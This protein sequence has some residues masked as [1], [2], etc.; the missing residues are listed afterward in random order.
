NYHQKLVLPNKVRQLYGDD[1]TN[2]KIGVWGLSFKPGTD[3]M[4]EAS[5][6]VLLQELLAYNAT[7]QA[8]DPVSMHMARQILPS[9]WLDSGRLILSENQYQAVKDVDALI[10]VTEWKPFCYPDLTLMKKLMR[11]YIV[12]DGRNQYDPVH[13]K[14]AEFEYYGIGRGE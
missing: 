5:S 1:L 4:R 10:L 6:L 3:D 9:E 12:L 8:Y 2:I 7:V 11:R 13:M 14:E